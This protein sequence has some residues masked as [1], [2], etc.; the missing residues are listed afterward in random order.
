MFGYRASELIGQPLELLIPEKSR[1]RHLEN[2]AAFFANPRNRPM[3]MG[4]DLEAQRK[5]GGRFPIEVSLNHVDTSEGRLGIACISDITERKRA[6]EESH[7]SDVLN[8]KLIEYMREGLAYCRM[9]VENGFASDL[10][11]DGQ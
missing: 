10:L 4:L 3:G 5:D 2:Q 1:N 8:H 11:S 6:E 7:R 9:V